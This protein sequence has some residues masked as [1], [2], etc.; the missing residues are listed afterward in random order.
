MSGPILL[1]AC[2]GLLAIFAVAFIIRSVNI[3]RLPVHLRWEL[4]PVPKEKTRGRYGG[5]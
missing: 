5:S 3:A 2:Y 1:A 4:A